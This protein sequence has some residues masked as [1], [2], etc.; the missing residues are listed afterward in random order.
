[1]DTMTRQEIIA[2]FDR[3]AD[4]FAR[5]DVRALAGMY[6]AT[7]VVESPMAGGAVTGPAAI[8]QL[9]EAL[10]KTFP[11]AT[12]T[13]EELVID[14]DR[15]AQVA[16]LAGTDAGGFLGLPATGSDNCPV[17]RGVGCG[18]WGVGCGVWGVTA[19]SIRHRRRWCAR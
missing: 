5:R 19:P 4:A 13:T 7:G 1:M 14:G 12:L 11:D 6:A 18:V 2:L 15:V 9:Y 8:A 10:F 17:V 16:T 3:R